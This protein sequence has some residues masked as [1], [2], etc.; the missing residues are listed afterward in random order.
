MVLFHLV[1][2]TV[3]Y[4]L[5]STHLFMSILTLIV[6][7]YQLWPVHVLLLVLTISLSL[8]CFEVKT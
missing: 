7:I 5:E 3:I 1:V 8:A 4:R 6:D 2:A